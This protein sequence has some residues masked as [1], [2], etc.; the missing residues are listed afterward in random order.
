MAIA[1]VLAML[2][3]QNDSNGFGAGARVFS[4]T[5]AFAAHHAGMNA[6]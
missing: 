4:L 3:G 2:I 5:R 6:C 1:I